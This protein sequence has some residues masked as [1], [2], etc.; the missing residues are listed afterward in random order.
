MREV[1]QA[2]LELFAAARDDLIG[3]PLS[4]YI[5]SVRAIPLMKSG[6]GLCWLLRP[7]T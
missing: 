3:R 2:A 5:A 1:N 6:G 4:E 7:A